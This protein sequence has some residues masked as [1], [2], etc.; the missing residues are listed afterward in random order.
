MNDQYKMI[1]NAV[2]PAFAKVLAYALAR[3]YY[4]FC[5]EK[6]PEDCRIFNLSQHDEEAD[7]P[8]PRLEQLAFFEPSLREDK[9]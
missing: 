6:M 9:E 5:P 3:V 1:G 8:T 7:A 4:L 2:P